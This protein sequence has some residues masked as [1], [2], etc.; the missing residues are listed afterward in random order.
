MKP[1]PSDSSSA[2]TLALRISVALVFAGTGLE[3]FSGDPTSYW[4][5][6]FAAIGLGQWFRYFTGVV[7]TVGGLL[8]LIPRA[9]IL[10]AALLI[11]SMVGAMVVHVVVFK[12]PADSLFPGLYL[13]GVV[14]A[15]AKLRVSTTAGQ[16]SRTEGSTA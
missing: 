13:V 12:H 8:F 4:V 10:G 2:T 11:A 14:L 9:T 16:P 3:K 6:V 1:D 15:Y 5:H 7:E